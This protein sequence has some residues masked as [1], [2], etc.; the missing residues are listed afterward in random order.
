[1]DKVYLLIT[2][3]YTYYLIR[4]GMILNDGN[5]HLDNLFQKSFRY[6]HHKE[7]CKISLEEGVTPTGLK[8]RRDPAF[9]PVLAVSKKS[10]TQYCLM[11]KQ[12]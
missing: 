10:G 6:N 5:S 1:M 3:Y 12:I 11:R 7:N 4:K 8:L 2:L 9:L